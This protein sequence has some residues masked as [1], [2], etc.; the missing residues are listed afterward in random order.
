MN[1]GKRGCLNIESLNYSAKRFK[2]KI[3]GDPRRTEF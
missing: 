3:E 1:T 2:Q